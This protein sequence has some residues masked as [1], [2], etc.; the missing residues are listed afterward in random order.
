[1]FVFMS[2]HWDDPHIQLKSL[3]RCEWIAGSGGSANLTVLIFRPQIV[4]TFISIPGLSRG[5]MLSG[6]ATWNFQMQRTDS[7]CKPNANETC[8]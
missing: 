3:S 6:G 8:H 5:L 4:T 2:H 1:M 7:S